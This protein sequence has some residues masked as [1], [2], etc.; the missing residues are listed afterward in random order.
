MSEQRKILLLAQD[1]VQASRRKVALEQ[2]GYTTIATT[3]LAS[4][5]TLLPKFR[6][7]L[8]ILGERVRELDAGLLLQEC[9]QHGVKTLAIVA[10]DQKS[11]I[12]SDHELHG[13]HGD[14]QLLERVR[15]LL[16]GNTA[17]A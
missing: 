5:G 1:P 3:A 2:A 17:T 8:V 15:A 4:A 16:T 12:E 11:R 6:P 9:R 7:D 13:H 10:P 14:E